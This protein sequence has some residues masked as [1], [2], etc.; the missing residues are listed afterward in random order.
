[1]QTITDF[2]P[3]V[4]AV[5][6]TYQIMILT[7][8][9]ALVS[10]RIGDKTFANHTN[11]IRISTAGVHRICVPA[12]VLDSAGEYTVVARKMIERLAYFSKT[13]ESVE[14]TYKFKP[15][16]KRENI[17]IYHLADVH[18][19]LE[20]AV[21]CASLYEGKIDLLILNGDI[22]SSSDTFDDMTR[23]YKIASRITKG[24][25]PCIMSRGNHDLR[26]LG[27][28][29]LATLMPGDNGK[30]Y[31]TLRVGCIW[32]ILVDTG[33]DK[34]DNHIE[35]G[36]TVACHQFREEQEE[37]IKRVIENAK[38]E[39]RD[40]GVLYKLVI[41]HVPFTFKRYDPFDIERGMYTSWSN[42]L[43]KNVKPNLMLCGHTH[44]SLISERGSKE[45]DLG[46]P[47]TVVVGANVVTEIANEQVISRTLTGSYIT[48]NKNKAVV[49]FNSGKKIESQ[50]EISLK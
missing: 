45:D 4:C 9:D 26:G 3:A 28:E 47:C 19:E 14:R 31:Y 6:N 5:G 21:E 29:K 15:L 48:L 42:L 13:E 33:E 35:Y 18:G 20:Q 7:K 30:S 24:E 44:K 10:V 50:H 11:G 32:A 41:S 37:M 22:S 8:T 43:R 36:N 39:Y 38:S 12:K 46:H 16:E 25:F 34:E 40:K 27:A 49:V 17:N 1:M 2:H 23:C